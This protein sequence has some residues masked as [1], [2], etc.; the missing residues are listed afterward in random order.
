MP[1]PR[2]QLQLIAPSA[3]SAETAAIAA[4][5]EQFARATAPAAQN[6]QERPDPWVR[7]AILEGVTREDPEL[8]HPAFG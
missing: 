7:A 8:G 5:I 3:S 1:D 6:D 4:A 2:P